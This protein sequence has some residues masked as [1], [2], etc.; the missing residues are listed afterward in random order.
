MLSNTKLDKTVTSKT[1]IGSLSLYVPG[2]AVNEY[3]LPNEYNSTDAQYLET[4]KQIFGYGVINLERATTPGTNLYFYDGNNIVSA[5]GNAYW[6]AAMNTGFRGSPALNLGRGAID[7]VA[8]DMLESIDGSMQLP[9]IWKNSIALD[10]GGRHGLYM[11][12]VL[13]D[14]RVH[15]VRPDM[16][17][18]GNLS[19]GLARSERAYNDNMNGLD[20]M[21]LEYAT[22]NW[23]LG[24][25]YQ[26]YLTDGESRFTGVIV[27]MSNFDSNAFAVSADIGNFS[28]GASMPLAAS[29]GSAGYAYADYDIIEDADGRYDLAISGMEIR[30]IDMAPRSREL[31][32]NASYHHNFGPFTDGAIGFIYRV[33]PN[34]ID[35]YGNESIFMMK[36]SH[37]IGI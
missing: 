15:T 19:F 4:F 26:H 1:P 11:G 20:S 3:H 2:R 31:R 37:A 36:L 29:N 13:S 10:D 16:I 35:E 21:R 8:Y 33:N 25:D 27:Q 6:R 24:A 18:F 14:F 9:R 17:K 5:A 28:F 23:N 22:G 32:F 7:V 12:D 34:N 30:H